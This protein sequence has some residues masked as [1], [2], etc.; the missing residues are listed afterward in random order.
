MELLYKRDS[1]GCWSCAPLFLTVA[2][3]GRAG[4]AI[5]TSLNKLS[6]QLCFPLILPFHL[7]VTLIKGCSA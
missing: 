3:V 1:A 5:T 2:L 4:T 7:K 6:S